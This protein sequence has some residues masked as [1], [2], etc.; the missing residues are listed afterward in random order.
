MNSYPP[1]LLTQ[2]APVMF[3]AGLDATPGIASSNLSTKAQDFNILTLRLRE[4]LQ[5]QRTAAFW[6]PEKSQTFQVI[7]VD[8]DAKFP[9]RKLVSPDDSQYTTAHSPLSPLTPTSPL[10]P[11]G[12]IAPIWIRKHIT[13][14]PSVFVLF[15]SLFEFPLHNSR[16]PLDVPNSERERDR[17]QEERRR[18]SDLAAEV[19]IRKKTT[20]E[21]GIKLTVVLMASRK[22]LGRIIPTPHQQGDLTENLDDPTLDARLSYIRRQSGLDSRAAL[23]VLSPVSPGELNEFVKRYGSPHSIV[24]LEIYVIV[25]LQQALYEPALEYYTAHSKRVRRKRNRHSQVTT[26]PIA[27]NL[28]SVNIARPLRPEGWTVRYE[29]KMACFAEFRGEDEVALKSVP[30][31]YLYAWISQQIVLDIIKM[32]TTCLLSCLDQLL[33]YLRVPRG[34]QRRKSLQIVSISRCTFFFCLFPPQ[35]Y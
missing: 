6:Q 28:G 12:L 8:R 32:R 19:A 1:E 10:Y 21:R 17:E 35:Y 16:T 27:G 26:Y 23:F 9:P 5:A 15:T 11:D 20:N 3:V 25:S 30:N 24:N 14:V 2:L 22:M 7:L 29:C 18:D 13:L 34:G 33:S 31:F 4:A